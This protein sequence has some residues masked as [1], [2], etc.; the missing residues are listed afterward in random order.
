MGPSFTKLY[1]LIDIKRID[2]LRPNCSAKLIVILFAARKQNAP[3]T[4]A[5][6]NFLIDGAS[7]AS[8]LKYIV[9]LRGKRSH[10]KVHCTGLSK[11]RVA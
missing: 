9:T 8:L 6:L 5:S 11:D 4:N 10:Q 3:G 2:F 1:F 7:R